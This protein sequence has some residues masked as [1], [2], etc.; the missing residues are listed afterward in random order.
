MSTR[1][2]TTAAPPQTMSNVLKANDWIHALKFLDGGDISQAIKVFKEIEP[3][4]SKVLYNIGSLILA[5][6]ETEDTPFLQ[7]F[8]QQ[9]AHLHPSISN[10][11]PIQEYITTKMSISLQRSSL[12]EVLQLYMQSTQLDTFFA[13]GHFQ[14]GYLFEALGRHEEAIK[15]YLACI[16][17][18][19]DSKVI[20]YEQ[21]GIDL[22]LCLCE[23]YFNLA[24]I[25]LNGPDAYE[26][27]M[28]YLLLAAD[29]IHFPRHE[30]IELSLRDRGERRVPFSIK[31]GAIFRPGSIR[32][33]YNEAPSICTDSGINSN[34]TSNILLDSFP[35]STAL[36]ETR[37]KADVDQKILSTAAINVATELNSK[38]VKIILDK[39][40]CIYRKWSIISTEK[41]AIYGSLMALL[42]EKEHWY[43]RDNEGDWASI[44]SPQDLEIA[45]EVMEKEKIFTIT[46]F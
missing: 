39:E 12:E 21:L 30:R 28:R 17:S 43:F 31:K 38:V 40:R 14:C 5:A 33:L 23:A 15:S 20:D 41:E 19:R 42:N 29:N 26:E 2:S 45:L 36:Q 9:Q 18:F 44:T 35:S 7:H 24:I 25:Y 16:N 11:A 46:K 37:K 3:P 8:I 22:R 6:Q 4:T 32:L 1:P 13:I 10:E 34:F 27:G